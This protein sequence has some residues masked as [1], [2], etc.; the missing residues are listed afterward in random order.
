M[1]LIFRQEVYQI[2]GAAIEV[3]RTLGAGFLEA[4]YQEELLIELK[5]R[6]IP[7]ENQKPLTVT[8]KNFQLSKTYFAD[9]VCFGH[10]LVELKAQEALS[11]KESSQILNY[12]KAG[13]F[14]VGLLINFGSINRLEWR[15][16]INSD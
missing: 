12:M 8:Y 13:K 5:E 7:F 1:T 9:L 15:R 11:G 2:I 10:I 6:K 14:K 3:H 4:I 16:L